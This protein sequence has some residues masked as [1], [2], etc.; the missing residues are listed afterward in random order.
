MLF[1]G[2]FFD[3]DVASVKHNIVN[4]SG[5]SREEQEDYTER[6]IA[7]QKED[8]TKEVLKQEKRSC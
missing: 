4:G 1:L 5:E 8:Q 7:L 6:S 2:N 3:R